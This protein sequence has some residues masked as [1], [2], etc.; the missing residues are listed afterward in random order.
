MVDCLHNIRE[1]QEC[2]VVLQVTCQTSTN[3]DVLSNSGMS[4][5]PSM[6]RGPDRAARARRTRDM[7][8]RL[9]MSQYDRNEPAAQLRHP[10]GASQLSRPER[11]AFGK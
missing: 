6:I 11:D 4:D 5:L 2:I 1:K 8:A 7:A 3:Q 9:L 10:I